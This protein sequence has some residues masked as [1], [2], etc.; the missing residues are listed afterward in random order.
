MNDQIK[1]TRKYLYNHIS[2][3]TA[4]V[5]TDYPWGFRLRTTIRYWIETAQTKTGG[6]RLVTQ[7]INPKTGLWC[8]PKKT[9]YS[10]IM[11]L[12]LDEKNHIGIDDLTTYHCDEKRINEF[13]EN[14]KD[15]LTSFQ[16]NQLK[17]IIALNTVMKNVTFT[18]KPCPVEPVSLLS[19]DPIDIE[20]RRQLLIEE[21]ERKKKNDKVL[22]QISRAV[23]YELQKVEI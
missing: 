14:H 4:Y 2:P 15:K 6:Q 17:Q 10:A 20:K 3:E 22:D 11:V 8:A 18:V 9:T 19:Q 5:C 1:E 13:K 16:L 12:F 21:E 7:T 23:S